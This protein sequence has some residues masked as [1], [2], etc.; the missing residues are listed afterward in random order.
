MEIEFQAGS[1]FQ[2]KA[3][4]AAMVNNL[5]LEGCEKYLAYEIAVF[6]TMKVLL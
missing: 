4:I 1:K 3:L 6:S 2:D 5:I